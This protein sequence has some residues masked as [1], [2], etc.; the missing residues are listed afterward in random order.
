[1]K[2]LLL[3]LILVS[4]P[5][6]AQ[7]QSSSPSRASEVDLTSNQIKELSN[8]F[9]RSIKEAQVDSQLLEVNEIK[10]IV[11]SNK[12]EESDLNTPSVIATKKAKAKKEFED[13][14]KKLSKEEIDKLAQKLQL[15]SYGLVEG[16]TQG[17]LRDYFSERIQKA[18]Y[19]PGAQGERLKI[20]EMKIVDHKVYN[21][22]YESQLGKAVLLDLSNY[23]YNQLAPKS[24]SP[25]ASDVFTQWKSLISGSCDPS[26]TKSRAN[27]GAC[28]DS[29]DDSKPPAAPAGTS[30]PS[31]NTTPD[32]Y[33]ALKDQF[34]KLG[35]PQDASAFFENYFTICS[36]IIPH[37]CE[38]YTFCKASD[39][40]PW[41]N[42]EY[43][44]NVSATFCD[45]IQDPTDKKGINSCDV[46]ARLK[47]F[48]VNL[49][50]AKKN[51]DQYENATDGYRRSGKTFDLDGDGNSADDTY[52]SRGE[53]SIDSITTITSQDTDKILADAAKEELDEFTKNDCKNQPENP[54]C[55]AFFYNEDEALKFQQSSLVYTA[56]TELEKRRIDELNTQGKDKLEEYLRAKGYIDLA[57]KLSS[58]PPDQVVAMAKAR[59]ESER[60]SSF[61][62][63]EEAFNRRQV[64]SKNQG[65]NSSASTSVESDINKKKDKN[66][67]Q[68]VLF[69]NV[70]TSYLQIKNNK[71]EVVGDNKRVFERERERLAKGESGGD[72]QALEFFANMG[73]GNSNSSSGS[74]RNEVDEGN[75]MVS[76][77]F[78]DSLLQDKRET[79]P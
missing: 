53:N 55:K 47:A 48:R 18:L 75:S 46:Q 5:V 39:K 25:G 29:L 58:T 63:M 10:T 15:D 14:F 45:E 31:G 13:E 57:E 68:L 30:N 73:S 28:I 23:C 24:T 22:L 77:E 67:T 41:K 50:L 65:S 52:Q 70:I 16:K 76:V 27:L 6:W 17:K 72:E 56:A 54:E 49:E 40:T 2:S 12:I 26:K 19:G 7:T 51:K 4:R 11:E 59:F 66:F 32:P 43:F 69:N 61:K 36:S 3:V 35:S 21:D 34:S 38:A 37:M 62:K 71:N 33:L 8:R 78:I 79:T 42:D 1:M 9:T 20:K 60:E 64:D 74:S 44:R